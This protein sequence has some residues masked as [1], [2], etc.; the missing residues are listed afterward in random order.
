MRLFNRMILPWGDAGYYN[1]GDASLHHFI[2]CISFRRYEWS[3]CIILKWQFK[4]TYCCNQKQNQKSSRLHWMY[5]LVVLVINNH[6]PRRK[7]DIFKKTRAV[8]CRKKKKKKKDTNKIWKNTILT[9]NLFLGDIWKDSILQISLKEG[10]KHNFLLLSV[11]VHQTH[12]NA[13]WLVMEITL[14]QHF[15]N[16]VF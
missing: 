6:A 10:G 2:N 3:N 13:L 11:E 15:E 8:F 14:R 9:Q 1:L 16:E 7:I 12:L 5:L 4:I